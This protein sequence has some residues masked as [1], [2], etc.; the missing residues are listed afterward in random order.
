MS[1]LA[2]AVT[3]QV[4]PQFKDEFVKVLTELALATRKEAGNKQYDVCQSL[5]DPL[6]FMIIERWESPAALD[7]HLTL[8]HFEKFRNFMPGKGEEKAFVKLSPLPIG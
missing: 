1:E 3:L 5:D 8:P 2:L 7:L 6:T 4:K